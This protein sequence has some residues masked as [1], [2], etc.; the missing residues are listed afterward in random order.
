MK[1]SKSN[2]LFEKAKQF[3]PGGVNSPVRAFKSVGTNPLFI[4][5]AKGSKLWDVDGNEFIDYVG[6]WGPMLLG[7]SHPRIIEVV[8]KSAESGTSFGAPTE[9]EVMM[10]ELITKIM[11]SIEMVRMVNSGTE[12]TMSAIRLAR[13][14]TGKDKI[15]KF[16]GCY[17]GHGDSFLIKAGSGAMTFGV[18]DSPG[19]PKGI[20]DYTLTARFNDIASVEELISKNKSEIAALIVEPVVGNM[21]CIPPRDNF[22]KQLRELCTRENIVLIFDEVM[23]GFRVSLGGAQ[24]L[25]GI[26]PDLTTLGK[27]IGGGLPVGAYGGKKEIMQMVAPSGPMY[28]AGT[29]SGNPLAMAAGYE[30]LSIISQDKSVYKILEERSVQLENG[31]RDV[32]KKNNLNYRINRV[33]SMFTLFFTDKEVYDYD[34]AKTSDTKIFGLFFNEMLKRG[35]YLAPSQFE[36]AFISAAHT[37]DDIEKTNR[38]FA[39]A[40]EIIM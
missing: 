7:H 14:Y 24:E 6:S 31:M 22:L 19:I 18:P 21:G 35:I 1:T 11:P 5:K 38:V 8:K 12:A 9:L 39:E 3:I 28:Q 2:S 25:Y 34:S 15:I 27:I 10:A 13:A 20:A 30:M 4:Q 26:K 36:A 17:H 29:L 23:T 16:E 40:I 33:G 32:L 37:E